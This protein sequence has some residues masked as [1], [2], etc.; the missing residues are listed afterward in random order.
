MLAVPPRPSLETT[1][2]GLLSTMNLLGAFLVLFVAVGCAGPSQY[3]YSSQFDTPGPGIVLWP[4]DTEGVTWR[5]VV[6]DDGGMHPRAR[7]RTVD[8]SQETAWQLGE[9]EELTLMVTVLPREASAEL[10]LA[11]HELEVS[12]WRAY[13]RANLHRLQSNFATYEIESFAELK[14]RLEDL[15]AQHV[16]Q[17]PA[18]MSQLF[19]PGFAHAVREAAFAEISV[20]PLAGD[21]NRFALMTLA[22]TDAGGMFLREADGEDLLEAVKELMHDSQAAWDA[23]EQTSSVRHLRSSRVAAVVYSCTPPQARQ[24]MDELLFALNEDDSF[25]TK[26]DG[27][28]GY[29]ALANIDEMLGNRSLTEAIYSIEEPPTIEELRRDVGQFAGYMSH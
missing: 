20:L 9:G 24:C 7:V 8:T 4:A 23:N 3:Y 16:W 28:L 14:W 1:P 29:R 10:C 5:Y 11:A 12:I 27:L 21:K 15:E 13:P 17:R 26:A 25:Q 6:Q 22:P 18:A 19:M 2:L